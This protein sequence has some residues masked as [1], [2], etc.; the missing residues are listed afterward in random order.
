MRN[1]DGLT[2]HWH[3][4]RFLPGEITPNKKSAICTAVTIHEVTIH[5]VSVYSSHE[6]EHFILAHAR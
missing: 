2:A 3:N 5:E 1:L 6:T 4:V